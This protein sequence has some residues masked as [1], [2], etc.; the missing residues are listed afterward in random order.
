M[1]IPSPKSK[2]L[3]SLT[4][5]PTPILTSLKKYSDQTTLTLTPTR[6]ET[7]DLITPP[8]HLKIGVGCSEAAREPY[9]KHVSSFLMCIVFCHHLHLQFFIVV[10]YWKIF[11]NAVKD[12][13][14]E[15]RKINVLPPKA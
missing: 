3:P 9:P 2:Q 6:T 15:M 13:G 1:E 4:I 10:N 7:M 5:T 14:V 12:L 11:D 8:K